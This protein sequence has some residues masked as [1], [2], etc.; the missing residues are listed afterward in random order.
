MSAKNSKKSKV[1]NRTEKRSASKPEVDKN[2]AVETASEEVKVSTPVAPEPEPVAVKDPNWQ[3]SSV[4]AAAMGAD[5]NFA[6]D[7]QDAWRLV[8]AGTAEITVPA[9][10]IHF[11]M[12]RLPGGAYYAKFYGCDDSDADTAPM[13]ICKAYMKLKGISLG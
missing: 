1:S 6:T 10:A 5:G 2:E 3:M 13:A 11:A 7:I 9:P 12:G 4:L 8:E